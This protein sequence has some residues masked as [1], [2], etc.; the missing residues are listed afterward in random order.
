MQAAKLSDAH[1]K[2]SNPHARIYNRMFFN[3]C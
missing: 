2:Q 3:I 1:Q